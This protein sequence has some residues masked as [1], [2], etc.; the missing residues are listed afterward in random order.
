M[1]KYSGLN[2]SRE[3]FASEYRLYLPTE[4]KL[5]IEIDGHWLCVSSGR[6][7]RLRTMKRR[8]GLPTSRTAWSR[9]GL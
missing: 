5:R 7:M 1:V 8:R 6:S 9:E 4:E 3:L 2:E